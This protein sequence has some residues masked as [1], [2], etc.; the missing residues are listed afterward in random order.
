MI[1][2]ENLILSPFFHREKFNVIW[3]ING[4]S[5]LS[6]KSRKNNNKVEEISSYFK[7]YSDTNKIKGTV[8]SS[9]PS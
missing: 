2:T 1:F 3:Q 8:I 9:E 4:C 6:V 5:G 7:T